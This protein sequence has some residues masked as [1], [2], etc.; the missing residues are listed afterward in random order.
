MSEYCCSSLDRCR[1]RD[2]AECVGCM[3]PGMIVQPVADTL[4]GNPRHPDGAW[5]AA[6]PLPTTF[7]KSAAFRRRVRKYG[8]GCKIK[9]VP[10]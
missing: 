3:A 4:C 5:H 10:R 9:Q 2:K 7:R 1:E 6:T 8:C